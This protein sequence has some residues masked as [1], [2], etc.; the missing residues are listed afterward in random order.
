M[1]GPENKQSRLLHWLS[2]LLGASGLVFALLVAWVSI[3][4]LDLAYQL[5][6]LQSEL[7]RK[8]D[9]QA[10]LEVERM[11]LLSSSRLRVLAEENDLRQAKPGQIRILNP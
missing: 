1:T 4:R 9:L 3:E 7:E 2:A 6:Q 5:K 11:N 10:K 8:T